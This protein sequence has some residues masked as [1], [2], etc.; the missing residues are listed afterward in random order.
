MATLPATLGVP[1]GNKTLRRY[2]GYIIPYTGVGT[3]TLTGTASSTGWQV[4]QIADETN[5]TRWMLTLAGTA[6]AAAPVAVSGAADAATFTGTISDGTDSCALTIT[7]EA[8]AYDIRPKWSD[9]NSAHEL[10]QTLVNT[11]ARVQL[12]D[13]IRPRAGVYG[14][15]AGAPTTLQGTR[16]LTPQ[17]T[18]TGSNYVLVEP[19]T[20]YECEWHRL[21]LD[22]NSA[23]P[24][25]SGPAYLDFN[26]IRWRSAMLTSGENPD[27]V[28]MI[29]C[30]SPRASHYVRVRNCRF[31]GEQ[32]AAVNP[33]AGTGR[34]VSQGINFIGDYWT[35]ED[36]D[37]RDTW[38]PIINGPTVYNRGAIIR[39]NTV[40]RFQND[41]LKFNGFEFSVVDNFATNK[42]H[43]DP[44]DGGASGSQGAHGDFVQH[45]GWTDGVSRTAG[46]V[47]RNI[48][49]RGL[50]RASWVDGQGVFFD[51]CNN[52]SR[53]LS[54]VI[55]NNIYIGTFTNGLIVRNGV[56][57]LVRNNVLLLDPTVGN[58]VDPNTGTGSNAPAS[59]KI[60]F[61]SAPLGA[62]GEGGVVTGNVAIGTSTFTGVT[63]AP[64]VSN[65]FT[66][67][68][69]APSGDTSYSANFA[70]PAYGSSLSTAAAVKAA[71]KPKVGGPIA[72]A[73]AGP[74]D[75]DGNWRVFSG[76]TAV[77][78][79]GPTGG[80]ELIASTNFT[81]GADGTITG[82]VTV[83][84]NDAA[85]GGTFTPASVQISA[86]SPT[87]TFTYTPPA[88]AATR[89]VSVTNSGGLANPAAI[90]YTVTVS[91]ITTVT[92][93]VPSVLYL[94]V[95]D[96]VTA[97]VN[98]VAP[99]QVTVTLDAVAG[100]TF[101][102]T[103]VIAAG[104]SSGATSITGTTL[105][106]KTIT[107]SDDAGLTGPAAVE[108]TV[109][110]APTGRANRG[111]LRKMGLI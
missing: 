17:G 33:P 92:V 24:S 95:A 93:T 73:L 9:T 68:A 5:V 15:V 45:T 107:G 74:L 27:S 1:W 34:D 60:G 55:E 50:G 30:T 82:T 108:T 80:V 110:S 39:R 10:R 14:L 101:G 89:T 106:A 56:D 76:A 37:F 59:P 36:N 2:G 44:A 79:S 47:A 64:T 6:G 61:S 58:T 91:P 90:S 23:T 40:S 63:P 32:E 69:S 35:I 67:S 13:K 54:L 57:P 72:V 84:P 12:G 66:L 51:D 31:W 26:Q 71:F 86:A 62:G 81:V 8:P 11:V 111:Q 109:T 88:G 70:A 97:T 46:T 20:A 48:L 16:F 75:T 78:L 3:L 100:L 96:A 18:W 85:A 42:L 29:R 77:T 4:E 28:S 21:L 38:G 83:T 25:G 41:F 49:V 19:R 103:I 104:Q 102:G 7:I 53:L 105:G 65:H 87:A 52:G 43:P 94:D 98:G 99:S 22:S